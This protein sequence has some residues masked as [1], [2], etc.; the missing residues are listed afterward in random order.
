MR[1]TGKK[2]IQMEISRM[3][4]KKTD[5]KTNKSKKDK[6]EKIR[7]LKEQI[8]NGTYKVDPGKLAQMMI[9]IGTR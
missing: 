6:S 1:I 9:H 5:K 4:R 8:R 2:S 3:A 7:K